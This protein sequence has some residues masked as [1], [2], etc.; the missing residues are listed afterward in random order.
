VPKPSFQELFNKQENADAKFI[1]ISLESKAEATNGTY[2]PE[3]VKLLHVH[4]DILRKRCELL[5]FKYLYAESRDIIQIPANYW[6]YE[7][8]YA[9]ILHLYVGNVDAVLSNLSFGQLIELYELC[10]AFDQP[11]LKGKLESPLKVKL[12]HIISVQELL[13]YKKRAGALKNRCIQ[14]EIVSRLKAVAQSTDLD[15]LD[16]KL[17]DMLLS[18]LSGNG[19]FPKK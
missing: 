2:S 9:F 10:E 11:G 4:K 1:F 15:Q 7:A 6:S 18:S 17:K 3:G 16:S 8:F 19:V 12:N 14:Q 13:E 5:H